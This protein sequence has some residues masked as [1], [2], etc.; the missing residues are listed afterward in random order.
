MAISFPSIIL[1]LFFS[2]LPLLF[3]GYG[4]LY[5]SDHM[6]NRAR[7][8]AGIIG[9]MISI[10]CIYL[11]KWWLILSGARQLFAV[12]GVFI[13]LW[14][15]STGVT[16]FWSPYIRWFLRRTLFFSYQHIFYTSLSV[17]IISGI[18]S[19][20]N[21]ITD[22]FFRNIWIFYRSILRRM[23]ETYIQHMT[24]FSGVSVF[25][26]RLS[27]FYIFYYSWVYSRGKYSL[28]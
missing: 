17:G 15:L 24:N 16:Y 4:N 5:L 19:Y 20:E 28:F 8:F 23:S 22:V 27:S 10:A 14:I 26:N 13:V 2:F 6:W 3:W 9:W 7:F 18:Y 25:S 11:F 1:I 12:I 21:R